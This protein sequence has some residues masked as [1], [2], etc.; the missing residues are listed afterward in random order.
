VIVL[1]TSGI[2]TTEM[3]VNNRLFDLCLR[4]AKHTSHTLEPLLVTANKAQTPPKKAKWHLG[5]VLCILTEQY[6]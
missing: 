1:F 2:N 6:S 3:F 5:K 4:K